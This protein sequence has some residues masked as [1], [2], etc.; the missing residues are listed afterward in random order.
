MIE[1]SLDGS[2]ID[3]TFDSDNDVPQ[4][5]EENKESGRLEMEHFVKTST[6]TGA[7]EILQSHEKDR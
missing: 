7:M 3:S 5:G 4:I 2:R 1:S 6:F